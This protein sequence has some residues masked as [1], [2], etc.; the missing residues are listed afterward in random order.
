[1]PGGGGD[2]CVVVVM[3]LLVMVRGGLSKCVRLRIL[4]GK[5]QKV[6]GDR[7]TREGG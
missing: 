2:E 1:M 5:S 7:V 3:L 4:E 6:D